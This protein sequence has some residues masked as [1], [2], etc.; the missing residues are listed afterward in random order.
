MSAFT[1]ASAEYVD[2]TPTV[3]DVPVGTVIVLGDLV[4]YAEQLIKQNTK[5][6]LRVSGQVELNADVPALTAGTVVYWDNTV[7][8]RL[9]A[10]AGANKRAGIVAADKAINLTRARILLGR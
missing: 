3:A 8:Q 1:I 10:T 5:G 6:A 9:T 2:Y 4:G 7:N